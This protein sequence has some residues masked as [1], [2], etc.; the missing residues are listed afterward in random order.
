MSILFT[1]KYFGSNDGYESAYTVTT[2]NLAYFP[3][4]TVPNGLDDAS[5]DSDDNDFRWHNTNGYLRS[6]SN[7]NWSPYVTRFPSGGVPD[8]SLPT[9]IHFDNCLGQQYFHD[10]WVCVW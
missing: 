4:P 10:F 8:L 9:N 3:V 2:G 6:M 1:D 7:N 5:D